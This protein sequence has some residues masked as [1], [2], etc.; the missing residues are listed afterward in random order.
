MLAHNLSTYVGKEGRG[1]WRVYITWRGILM[2]MTLP[3]IFPT[4]DA[5]RRVA[6]AYTI[7]DPK[8]G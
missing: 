8:H 6:R 1:A 3:G 4:R 5:A 2:P 7:G